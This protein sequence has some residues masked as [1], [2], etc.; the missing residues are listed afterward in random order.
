MSDPSANLVSSVLGCGTLSC[1][2][3]VSPVQSSFSDVFE[4]IRAKPPCCR[5]AILEAIHLT[6]VEESTRAALNSI[7]ARLDDPTNV[8]IWNL[9]ATNEGILRKQPADP[10]GKQADSFFYHHGSTKSR[11]VYRLA[12]KEAKSR[13]SNMHTAL[14]C[15]LI[16]IYD[17]MVVHP[18]IDD[19][20]KHF[21]KRTQSSL[22]ERQKGS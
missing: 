19:Y 9:D 21:E 12:P 8:K 15:H 7:A 10:L 6:E 2:L 11:I 4:A 14:R 1:P 17:A 13:I 22:A 16:K 3:R 20:S 5:A 18:Q